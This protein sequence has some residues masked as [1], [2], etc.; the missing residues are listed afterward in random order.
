MDPGQIDLQD[1]AICIVVEH[2][3]E[4]RV[5]SSDEQQLAGS[6]ADLA[7]LALESRERIQAEAALRQSEQM[8]RERDS[9]QSIQRR[10]WAW[11]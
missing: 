8:K 5:W 11:Q 2:V 7:S 4:A 10:Q 1:S 6:L 3:G 9:M